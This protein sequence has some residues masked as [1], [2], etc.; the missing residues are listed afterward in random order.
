M[1]PAPQYS[2]RR[3]GLSQMSHFMSVY[4]LYHCVMF[5]YSTAIFLQKPFPIELWHTLPVQR[6]NDN[7]LQLIF[8]RHTTVANFTTHQRTDLSYRLNLSRDGLVCRG[9]RYGLD[10][11]SV[12]RRASFLF[13]PQRPDGSGAHP[14]SCPTERTVGVKWPWRGAEFVELCLHSSGVRGGAVGW[15]TALQVG[16]SRV[17]FPMVSLT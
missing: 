14:A 3:C 16:R 15:G 17:R 1:P 4:V 13:S 2:V 6:F 10:A 12:A 11:G 9:W 5:H 8:Q 7:S